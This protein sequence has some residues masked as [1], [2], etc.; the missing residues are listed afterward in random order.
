MPDRLAGTHALNPSQE[1][2][3]VISEQHQN[4]DI[5]IAEKHHKDYTYICTYI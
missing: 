4:V 1:A 5:F 2:F 3:N